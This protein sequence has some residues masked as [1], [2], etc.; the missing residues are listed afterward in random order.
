[1]GST[2]LLDFLSDWIG[3]G[4][5][6]FFRSLSVVIHFNEISKGVVDIRD[7]VYF[8][9]VIVLFLFLNVVA[10]DRLKAS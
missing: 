5:V 10:I 1:M 2:I 6:E 3:G 7:I 9:S 4:V 8:G